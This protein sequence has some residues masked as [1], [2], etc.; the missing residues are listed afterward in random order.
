MGCVGSTRV[1]GPPEVTMRQTELST[2]RDAVW[3]TWYNARWPWD[4]VEWYHTAAVSL[5]RNWKTFVTLSIVDP[6]EDTQPMK[7]Q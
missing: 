4:W 1:V 6:N 3:L 5:S 7:A 2:L